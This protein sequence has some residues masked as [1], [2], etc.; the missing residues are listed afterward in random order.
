MASH[1]DNQPNAG[2]QMKSGAINEYWQAMRAF[3]PRLRRLL[4]AMA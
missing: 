2:Y 4:L 1:S 3:S